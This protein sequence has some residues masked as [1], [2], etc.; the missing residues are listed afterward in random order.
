[1]AHSVRRN[2]EETQPKA[3]TL[4]SL[5]ESDQTTEATSE[6][7]PKESDSAIGKALSEAE[8][9][10]TLSSQENEKTE[11]EKKESLQQA[12]EIEYASGGLNHEDDL[13][14]KITIGKLENDDALSNIEQC[15]KKPNFEDS[16]ENGSL[17]RLVT[18]ASID[19]AIKPAPAPEPKEH[20]ITP[21]N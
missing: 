14:L 21:K 19:D 16:E 1:M 15:S 4:T 10:E 17:S 3:Q 6:F 13:A 18:E 8:M 2:E 12:N 20:V 7:E 5:S 9:E 11:K